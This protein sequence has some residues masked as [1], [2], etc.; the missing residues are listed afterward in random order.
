LVARGIPE[1]LLHLFGSVYRG[2][3][4]LGIS[5]KFPGIFTLNGGGQ[6]VLLAPDINSGILCPVFSSDG[7]I[8]G[9]QIRV[10]DATNNKYRWLKSGYS[11]HLQNGE[12]PLTYVGD[13]HSDYIQFAEG[14]LKPF[15]I[16]ELSGIATIGAAGGNFIGSPE[17]LNQLVDGKESA[18]LTPDAGAIINEMLMLQYSH[19]QQYLAKK[20]ISLQVWW[21]GQFDKTSLDGDE[22][23]AAGRWGETELIGWDVFVGLASQEIRDY[24][25]ER[26]PKDTE[27]EEAEYNRQLTEDV[28]YQQYQAEGAD[29]ESRAEESEKERQRAEWESTREHFDFLKWAAKKTFTPTEVVKQQFLDIDIQ[30]GEFA[31]IASPTGT[32]KTQL[33]IQTSKRLGLGFFNIGSRNS[34]M[35]NSSE[36]CAQNGINSYWIH[37]GDATTYIPDKASAI[38]L[39]IDSLLRIGIEDAEG[40]LLVIDE[41]MSV[42]LH[43]LASS[44]CQQ[45]RSP[46]LR[47]LID[48]F[49]VAGGLITTDANLSDWIVAAIYRYCHHLKL[50]K[51]K[52]TYR[53][54]GWEASMIT[55][56]FNA[57]EQLNSRD[58]TPIVQEILAATK[59]I[60]VVSDSRN[61]IETLATLLTAQEKKVISVHSESTSDALVQAFLKNPNKVIEEYK[62]DAVLVSPTAESGLDVSIKDYFHHQYGLFY[63]CNTD[64]QLQMLGRFRHITTDRR[65]ALAEF[66]GGMDEMQIINSHNPKQILDACNQKLELQ[67]EIASLAALEPTEFKARVMALNNANRSEWEKEW[68]MYTAMHTYERQN[69]QKCLKWRLEEAGHTVTE[70]TLDHDAEA[71][72]L[73]GDA[74]DKLLDEKSAATFHSELLES[75]A[76]AQKILS[77][78]GANPSQRRAAE[79]TLLLHYLPGIETTE[80]WQP[81]LVRRMLHDEKGWRSQLEKYWLLLHPE[82]NQNISFGFW[83]TAINNQS[84]FFRPDKL[85]DRG[86]QVWALGELNI[87]DF[88]N[89]AG[90]W[91]NES[92]E[93]KRLLKDGNSKEIATALGF[94]PGKVEGTQYLGRLLKLVGLALKSTKARGDGGK[95]FRV[96]SVSEVGLKDQSRMDVLVCIGKKFGQREWYQGGREGGHHAEA[97]IANLLRDNQIGASPSNAAGV[98]IT[99][100][101]TEND[102]P[103]DFDLENQKPSVDDEEPAAQIIDEPLGTGEGQEENMDTK[104]ITGHKPISQS[105]GTLQVGGTATSTVTGEQVEILEVNGGSARFR[106]LNNSRASYS[107]WSNEGTSPIE[108]LRA[109]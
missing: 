102:L 60:A 73:F 64:M 44:T 104:N 32:G 77:T 14:V 9:F 4:V 68:A 95:L 55:G 108:L 50:R 45:Q 76:A 82:V 62:P 59:P 91:T 35:Q 69:M 25:S 54:S 96:Y 48:I 88:I 20:K 107:G 67:E 70:I 13:A 47:R 36:R 6:S 92:P 40:R 86:L 65:I 74:K 21:W 27:A 94:V 16:G 1:N 100:E 38:H 79:K 101:K 49:K 98:G 58:K 41:T 109:G 7:L 2:K 51:I 8:I 87:L 53:E 22:L 33:V 19:L 66:T 37:E 24:L 85:K 26:T 72:K 43:A 105:E 75:A 11:S 17:Q 93:I 39:C 97:P 28:S 81:Q 46:M 3:V 103:V 23:L 57:K 106:Y 90:A 29:A 18:I 42:L 84:E 63:W 89:S 30:L 15:I 83:D 12:L 31:A 61:A 5:Q 71:K 99:D 52:N 34:L 78:F 10:A 80:S 56:A